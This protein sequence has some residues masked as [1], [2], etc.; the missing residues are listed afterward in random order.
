MRLYIEDE[1]YMWYMNEED[2][3]FILID[4][5]KKMTCSFSQTDLYPQA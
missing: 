2:D 4:R 1:K 3:M 5:T